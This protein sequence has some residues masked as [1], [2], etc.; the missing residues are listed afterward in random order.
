MN[1]QSEASQVET[2]QA[3][4][5]DSARPGGT[6]RH[7][8][9][10]RLQGRSSVLSR[11]PA[12]LALQDIWEGW[13]D[14][15]EL[16]LALG[17]YDMRKRNRRS[18][19]GP[20]WITISLGAFI[21]AMG[22]IYS[23]MLGSHTHRYI[24]YI[25]FGFVAWQFV[26]ELVLEGST[27]FVANS[28][29]ILQLRAPLSL[30]LYE[31]VWRNLLILCANL[32]IYAFIVAIFSIPVTWA[33]L[34]VVPGIVLVSINGFAGGL[35]LGTLC[36][37]FRDIPPIIAAFMRMMFLVT[38]IIWTPEQIPGRRFLVDLNPLY[39]LI[40]IIRSPLLGVSPPLRIWMVAMGITLASIVIAIPFYGRYRNRIPYWV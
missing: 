24:P 11:L 29:R 35:I 23:P 5:I 8:P 9:T 22:I 34:L 16:W 31:V 38:P 1:E 19:L 37:R 7:R 28:G 13:R 2:E 20:L 4:A 3:P 10:A 40:E 32:L 17:W 39:Y 33:T 27:V 15:R 26:S 36:A 18:V 14:Y 12:G 30:Y 21:A 6:A 25:A